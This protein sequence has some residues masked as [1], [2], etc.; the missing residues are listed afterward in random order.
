[1]KV[2]DF[3]NFIFKFSNFFMIMIVF[4]V[5]ENW[6]EKTDFTAKTIF[7]VPSFSTFF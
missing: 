1:M 6:S 7:F 4:S 3:K 5:W 2:Y